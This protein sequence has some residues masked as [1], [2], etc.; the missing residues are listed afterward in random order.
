MKG[1]LIFHPSHHSTLTMCSSSLLLALFLTLATVCLCEEG[2][3]VTIPQERGHVIVQKRLLE[4]VLVQH[5]PFTVV[6]D[7]LNI[8]TE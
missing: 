7:V 8:G 6:Y 4:S 2:F 1:G 3:S 5:S